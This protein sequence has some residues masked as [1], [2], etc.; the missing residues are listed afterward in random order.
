MPIIPV[1]ADC[2]LSHAKHFLGLGLLFI[3]GK[4]RCRLMNGLSGPA[5]VLF[6]L[7]VA[8]STG[9][10]IAQPLKSKVR[11]MAVFPVDVHTRPGRDVYLD[12]FWVGQR[13]IFS[14]AQ[15]SIAATKEKSN[16]FLGI[17]L[18]TL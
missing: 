10:G 17:L 16:C 6:S 2:I 18:H 11:D 1:E 15:R 7:F 9:T 4:Q 12:R 13:H 3:H 5:M 8:G 14:I